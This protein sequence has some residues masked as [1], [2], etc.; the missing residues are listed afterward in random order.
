MHPR[1]ALAFAALTGLAA[2]GPGCFTTKDQVVPLSRGQAQVYLT[3]AKDPRMFGITVYRSAKG[4]VFEG[5]NRVHPNQVAMM[6]F[7]HR[8]TAR[9]FITP[10]DEQSYPAVTFDVVEKDEH[11]ALF[12]TSSQQSWVN[13]MTGQKL[14]VT[15][16]G[17]PV[18]EYTPLQAAGEPSGFLGVASK[19]RFDDNLRIENA[20][21]CVRLARG[22]LGR[23][24]RRDLK[25]WPVCVVGCNLMRS[26]AFLQ[27][28][29]PSRMLVLSSS[30]EFTPN[31]DLLVASMPLQDA[32]G[33]FAAECVID[34]APGK[35]V[36][37]TAG[38]FELAMHRPPPDA[39]RQLSLGNL[40]FRQIRAVE[41]SDED[42]RLL[43][44]PRIGR[45]LLSRYKITFAPKKEMVWFEKP[46][47]KPRFGGLIPTETV[48]P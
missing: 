7:R 39:V 30:G 47:P 36:F 14:H 20:L 22:P 11:L 28:D 27:F 24:A 37:D 9:R 13:F 6:H 17:P 43:P 19:L 31:L 16:L 5:A 12:D 45:R 41:L 25:P 38:D 42:H 29:Y 23:L 44:Y 33:V 10:K 34:G 15:P 8:A 3:K 4:P 40:V 26:F 35:V 2:L 18:F 21:L 48:R 1:T 46:P 32:D